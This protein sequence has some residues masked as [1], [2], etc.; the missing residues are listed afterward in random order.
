V[1]PHDWFKS[2]LFSDTCMDEASEEQEEEEL[3]EIKTRSTI[4]RNKE[5]TKKECE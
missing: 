5:A 2:S 4:R 1:A 3:D